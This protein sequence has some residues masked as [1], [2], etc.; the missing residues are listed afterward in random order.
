[1][2]KSVKNLR[3]VERY[4]RLPVLGIIPAFSLNRFSELFHRRQ[5]K[6]RQKA[7]QSEVSISIDKKEDLPKIES[8]E[9]ITHFLPKSKISEN[10]RSIRTALLLSP[11]DSKP[12]KVAVSSP[13]PQEGKTITI[14]NLAV[15]FAQTGKAVLIID[16][17]L[18]KPMLHKIFKM[19]NQN[20]LT[21]FLSGNSGA[22]NLVKKTQIPNLFL[23][24]SGP[25]LA[26]PLEL[27]SSEKM[28]HLLDS[29]K[30]HFEYV[31]FDTPPLLLL[32]D[33]IALGSKIDGVILVIWGGKT[34][35]EALKQSREKLD[36]HKIKCLGVII[37]SAD[38]R[39]PDYYY[40]KHYRHYY[41]Y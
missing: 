17:D 12:K 8:I 38:M 6:K 16:S 35:R 37:N 5:P 24:N 29:L 40:M 32:S 19:A 2:D 1:M 4:S 41:E 23:I 14:S 22:D 13:L 25:V 26:D 34:S 3:D 33:A 7:E 31:F 21:D 10:Y 18:R 28:T 39:E 15:T 11:M 9:L 30:E 27:L 20:G 36:K